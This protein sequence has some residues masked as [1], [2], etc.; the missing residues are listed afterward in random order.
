[1]EE[2]AGLESQRKE[3]E[4]LAVQKET[5]RDRKIRTIGNYVHDS[6][7]IS[8]NEVGDSFETAHC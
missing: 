1:L 8:N 2:K 6:V 4:E 5:L 7:P 3:A